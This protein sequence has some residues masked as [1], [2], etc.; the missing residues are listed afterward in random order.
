VS[1]AKRRKSAEE[2]P[3][4]RPGA[5]VYDSGVRPGVAAV[6]AT[7]GVIAA[8]LGALAPRRAQA[9][10]QAGATLRVNCGDLTTEGR[11]ALEARAR[12]ELASAPLPAGEVAVTCADRAAV[13]TWWAADGGFREANVALVPDQALAVDALLGTIEALRAGDRPRVAVVAPPTARVEG[14]RAPGPAR[15]DLAPPA[16]YRL[17]AVVG[18]EGELWQGAIGGALGARFGPR[19]SSPGGWSL[20][21]TGGVG[22]GLATTQGIRA[23]TLSAMLG[24]GYAPFRHLELGLGAEIRVLTAT[25]AGPTGST[26]L[27]D[28][29]EG[30][31]ASARYVL[32][33]GPLRLAIGPQ[34]EA[35]A[36]PFLVQVSGREVFRIPTFVAGF[37][38]DGASDFVR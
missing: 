22:W 8:Q 35:L 10:M 18:M 24:L 13:V 19:V 28:T 2:K 34:I 30:A 32:A 23:Q 26:E 31:L 37:S 33:R 12:A 25:A 21:I 36:Q 27:H 20:A 4:P 38:I 7:A 1:G 14:P 3:P 16:F 15:A 11:A 9:G 17:G 29:T 6:C 5:G